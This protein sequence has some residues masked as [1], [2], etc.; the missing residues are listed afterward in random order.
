MAKKKLFQKSVPWLLFWRRKRK[1]LFIPLYD[2]VVT[3]MEE[4]TVLTPEKNRYTESTIYNYKMRRQH[5]VEFEEKSGAIYLEDINPEWGD[6]FILF[7]M[8]HDYA[9]NTI[10]TSISGIKAILNI[11]YKKKLST[12]NG[13]GIAVSKELTTQVFN[14]IEDLQQLLNTTFPNNPSYELVRD[15]YVKHCFIGLRFGDYK[16]FL[17]D[18]MTYL[19]QHGNNDF[20]DIKTQ[21]TGEQVIIP[22][23]KIVRHLLN[24]HNYNFGKLFTYQ[25]YNRTIKEIGEAAGLTQTIICSKTQGGRRVDSPMRKCDM[26]S[27]HTARRSF[28]TNA[29]LSKDF[30]RN[31]IMKVT[32]HRS[33]ESFERYIRCSVLESAI[34]VSA[35]DFFTLN[36]SVPDTYTI[37]PGENNTLLP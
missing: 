2:K 4:G 13:A 11:L 33:A 26:M 32:G 30:N 34:N 6:E 3:W 28:A 25:Y 12:Y 17:L 1:T 10:G 14:S 29:S 15:V 35:N 16:R 19:R 8:D 37:G 9:K 18:P 23:A 7:M 24:K 22:V 27:S 36:F 21:K 5:L 31:A 20:I